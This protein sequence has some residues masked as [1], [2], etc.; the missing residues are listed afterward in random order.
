MVAVRPPTSQRVVLHGV[1]WD[2]YERLLDAHVDSS[3]PRFTYDRGDLEVMSPLPEHERLNRAVQLLVSLVAYETGV[4]VLSLGSATFR[5]QEIQRGF[6]PD[7]CFYVQNLRQVRGKTAIDLNV[8]PPPDLV[9]EID[10]TK[11]SLPKVPIYAA[12]GVPEV[13]RYHAGEVQI[14][15]LPPEAGQY[16]EEEA[17][18]AL[19]GVTAGWLSRLLEESRRLDDTEWMDRVR[20]AARTLKDSGT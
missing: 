13:W 5:R 2:I 6:E 3:S 10:M 9:V 12:F 17:S 18:Q 8:D 20:E 1:A 7:S 19:P 16:I 15:R 11:L 4:K 14:L